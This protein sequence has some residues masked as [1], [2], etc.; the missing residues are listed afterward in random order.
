MKV[1]ITRRQP[2]KV[3]GIKI[4]TRLAENKIEEL[5]AEFI[6]R[7]PE[8]DENAVPECTLGICSFIENGQNEDE[9]DYMAARVVKDESIIPEGMTY[10]IL[11]AQDIAVFTHE[12]SLDDLS[13]TYDNIYEEWLPESGYQIDDADEIEWY[14]SR[15]QFGSEKSQMDIHIP[16]KPIEK[17]IEDEIF[18]GLL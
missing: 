12:G 3:V 17:E 6:G 13:E 16:I 1:L 8:L 9:F 7:M 14:D 4:R 15:F 5:W 11:P 2:L 10:R 18:E